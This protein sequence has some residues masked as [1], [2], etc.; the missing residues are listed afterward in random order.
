LA[1]FAAHWK[2]FSHELGALNTQPEIIITQLGTKYVVRKASPEDI[3]RL[4]NGR[5]VNSRGH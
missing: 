3:K 1:L 5:E 2:K 4:S